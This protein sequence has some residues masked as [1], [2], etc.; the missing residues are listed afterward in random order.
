MTILRKTIKLMPN[1]DGVVQFTFTPS[2][3]GVY[4]V[5]V[6]G[7]AGSFVAIQP[8]EPAFIS[9]KLPPTVKSGAEFIP[10]LTL[11]LPIPLT[12]P[13]KWM[14]YPA[15][16]MDT[17]M[18]EVYLKCDIARHEEILVVRISPFTLTP[19]VLTNPNGIYTLNGVYGEGTPAIARI[20]IDK[21]DHDYENPLPGS[22][23]IQGYIIA[24]RGLWV[25][26][27]KGGHW[28]YSYPNPTWDLGIVGELVIV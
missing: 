18:Y 23:P 26:D 17:P 2:K 28:E 7:L 21:N 20:D 10:E 15:G 3:A 6:N 1:R 24:G 12:Y 13:A 16:T 14:E 9:L 5:S 8:S 4:Q 25:D 19:D 22:Y 11:Y 27:P